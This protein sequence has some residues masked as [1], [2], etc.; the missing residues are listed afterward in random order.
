MSQDGPLSIGDF[1]RI[2]GLS[3]SALRFY[4]AAGVLA[5]ARVDPNSGYRWYTPGQIHHARLIATL[6]R[7]NMPLTEMCAVLAASQDSVRAEHLLDVYLE[8]LELALHDAQRSLDEAREMLAALTP[9][10][11]LTVR[12]EDLAEALAAVQFAVSHDPDLPELNGVLLDYDGSTLRVVASDRYRLAVATVTTRDQTGPVAQAITTPSLTA[13]ITAEAPEAIHLTFQNRGL[14]V[15]DNPITVIAGAF[16]DYRRLL[17]SNRASGISVTTAEVLNRL[18]KGPARLRRQPPGDRLHEVSVVLM[19]NDHFRVLDRFHPDA[20]AFNREFLIEALT[21]S[22]ADE[23]VFTI[24]AA[25]RPL[26][27]TDPARPGH[28]NLLMPTR[29]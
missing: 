3:V 8:R 2:S 5:P 22:A 27:I 15:N 9:A 4:D 24:E 1:A 28:V 18:T 13:H 21:A 17:V 23:L 26:T 29:L 19:S 12:R 14:S 25:D 11:R 10:T 6:R 7:I 16:P 20:I